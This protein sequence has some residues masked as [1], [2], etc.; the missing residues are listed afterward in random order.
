VVFLNKEDQ[1]ITEE[2][3]LR[4]GC[5]VP[6]DY[7]V[8]HLGVHWGGRRRLTDVHVVLLGGHELA[9]AVG[10]HPEARQD[11]RLEPP[12]APEDCHGVPEI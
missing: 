6:D 10:P 5:T 2:R 7:H 8:H 12:L 1:Q 11:Q 4:A 3:H 9:A